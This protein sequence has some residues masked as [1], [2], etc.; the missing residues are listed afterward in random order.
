M[1]RS[2]LNALQ[3]AH[4]SRKCKSL[5]SEWLKQHIKII[6]C[7]QVPN[8]D[9][10]RERIELECIYISSTLCCGHNDFG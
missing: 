9:A 1:L 5:G 7:K 8:D 3:S 6:L 10:W 2:A 4:I